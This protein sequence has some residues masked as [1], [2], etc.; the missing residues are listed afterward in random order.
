MTI[1]P[2]HH[3]S[4]LQ[5]AQP[6]QPSPAVPTSSLAIVVEQIFKARHITRHHQQM[7]MK[8]M[9]EKTLNDQDQALINQVYEGLR[10][11]LLRVA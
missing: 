5:P 11:G 6:A 4:T 2:P 7:I 8:L 10:K 3:L 1:T 9:A